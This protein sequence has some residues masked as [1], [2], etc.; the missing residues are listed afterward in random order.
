MS[1]RVFAKMVPPVKRLATLNTHLLFF[2]CVNDV[3]PSEVLIALERLGASSA[4]VG[5]L[6]R[7]R[8]L[9]PVKVLFPFK[10][11]TTDTTDEPP[12]DLVRC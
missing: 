4:G 8:Q 3:V 9:V 7:V 1:L 5:P 2:P 6:L 12:L 10:A 11:G